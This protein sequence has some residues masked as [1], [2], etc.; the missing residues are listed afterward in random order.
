MSGTRQQTGR[1]WVTVDQKR[2]VDSCRAWQIAGGPHV[3]VIE[4]CQDAGER[5][6]RVQSAPTSGRRRWLLGILL[7]APFLS[8]ADATVANVA[9]PDIGRDTGASAAMLELVIGGYLVAFAALLITGARLGQR[10]GVRHMYCLGLAIFG[11]TSL[12]C[13]LVQGP[14]E[15]VIARVLQG[16]GAALMFPQTLTGIQLHFV[17]A[18]RL[19]AI[20]AFAVALSGG[21][22]LGQVCGGLLVEAAGWRAIF[23]VNVPITAVAIVLGVCFLPR[24]AARE[25]RRL[26]I[27]GVLT[28][29]ASTTL[30]LLPLTL[31]AAQGWPAWTWVSLAASVVFAVL[32]LVA[33]RHA[34]RNGGYPLIP[35][36]VLAPRA[37][38]AGLV[39]LTATGATYFGLLFVV[40]QYFQAGLGHSAVVSGMTMV[41]WVAAFGLAGQLMRRVPESWV[42][43]APVAGT[44]LLAVVYA[45][46]SLV[47][48]FAYEVEV[49][50]LALLAVGGFGLGVNF[51][52]MLTHVTNGVEARH[53]G[54]ISGV[55]NT[56]QQIGA[57]VGVAAFGSLYLAQS[58]LGPADSVTAT[59]AFAIVT[60]AFAAT[61]ALATVAAYS[62]TLPVVPRHTQQLDGHE[63]AKAVD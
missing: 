63:P 23:L 39:T 31:G 56:L 44:V 22:V 60:A 28:L 2:R 58:A 11:V 3:R 53:A 38:W 54:D 5:K 61:A 36:R 1:F 21:A 51:S 9:T 32:F 50:L 20:G 15:L 13:G 25:A 40:A 12:L 37:V 34:N 14:A 35:G 7:V 17:G 19:R 49:P 57:A 24:D 6:A 55:T 27:V 52:A 18:E 8:Q 29:M 46:M 62:S 10:R 59:R 33:E 41:P 4:Q 42:R 26:D 45:A 47:S 16:A 30:L 43:W 48:W